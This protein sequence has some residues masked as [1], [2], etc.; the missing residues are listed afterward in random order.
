MCVLKAAKIKGDNGIV[1]VEGTSYEMAEQ[2]TMNEACRHMA[3]WKLAGNGQN[4][5][6][7]AS[8]GGP[9]GSKNPRKG[10]GA[11]L[12]DPYAAPDEE[13]I[14]HVDVA[15]RMICA[16]LL[17][18]GPAAHEAVVN[19]LKAGLEEKITK[20]KAKDVVSALRYLRDRTGVPRDLPLAAARQ[21]RAHLNL[22]IN[23]LD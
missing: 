18:V 8:R 10:F 4:V 11:E 20:N 12:A 5:A 14:P 1:G 16:A 13:L 22:A 23:A 15:L 9:Q 6:R 3:G 2:T 17:A 7:F 21:L 19:E